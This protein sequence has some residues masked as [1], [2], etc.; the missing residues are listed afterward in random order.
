[1]V[2]VMRDLSLDINLGSGEF[3]NLRPIVFSGIVSQLQ[4]TYDT[5]SSNSIREW[6]EA[7]MS[8]SVCPECNGY[9]LKKRCS[10]CEE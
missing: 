9:R 6:I 1:M 10:K 8:V 5:T 3:G 7:Y 2:P 4:H